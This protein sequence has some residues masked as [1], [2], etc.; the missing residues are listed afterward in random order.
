MTALTSPIAGGALS[1]AAD[2]Y[3]AIFGNVQLVKDFPYLLPTVA[4]GA[5]SASMTILT[6]IFVKEVGSNSSILLSQQLTVRLRHYIKKMTR[7]YC[8]VDPCQC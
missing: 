2:Q 5:L 7:G 4:C 3:P 6:A 8:I 1:N